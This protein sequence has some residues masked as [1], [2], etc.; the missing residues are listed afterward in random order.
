[1]KKCILLIL[2]FVMMTSANTNYQLFFPCM[3]LSMFILLYVLYDAL[4][5][6]IYRHFIELDIMTT[7]E[8]EEKKNSDLNNFSDKE[9][10]NEFIRRFEK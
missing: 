6:K 4:M 7:Q 3:L 1:M 5:K 10:Q 2:A 9:I 8:K